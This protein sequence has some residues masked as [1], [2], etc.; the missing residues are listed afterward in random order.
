MKLK[1]YNMTNAA[2]IGR[3]GKSSVRVNTQSGAISFSKLSIESIG[4]VDS[5]EIE[6]LQD[7]DKP[8]DWYVKKSSN[9]NGFPIRIKSGQRSIS[10]V[11]STHIAREIFKSLKL[12]QTSAMFYMSQTPI[13]LE[14]SKLYAIITRSVIK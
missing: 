14:G 8:Q 13:E 10:I 7:E 6:F 1:S 9:G 2:S 11:Q 5:L 12:E 3:V 4:L